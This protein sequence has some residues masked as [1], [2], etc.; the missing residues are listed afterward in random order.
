M[1][2]VEGTTPEVVEKKRKK[3]EGSMGG[4]GGEGWVVAVSGLSSTKTGG[5]RKKIREKAGGGF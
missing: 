1:G 4:T 2:G 5:L 3:R